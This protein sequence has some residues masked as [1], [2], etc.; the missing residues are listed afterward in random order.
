MLSIAA[1][2]LAIALIDRI[3]RKPLLLAGSLGMALALGVV[4]FAFSTATANAAGVLSLP[5]HYGLIALAAANV[6]VVF[7]NA[8]WGPVMWVL[9]GEMFPN[10]IR[11]SA[12][13]VSGFAQWMANAAVSVSFPALSH[14]PG[15]PATYLGYAVFAFASFI[16]VRLMVDETRG[17]ALEDMAG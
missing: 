17:R 3:G 13:A 16:F 11:G 2:L 12:L 8:S 9:L 4:S 15:L 6:Y 14:R 7:F 10:R 5:G 1:C